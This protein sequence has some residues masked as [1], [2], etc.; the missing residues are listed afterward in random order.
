MSPPRLLSFATAL[1]AAVGLMW[2]ALYDP[3]ALPL[4]LL[5]VVHALA[6]L[7]GPRLTWAIARRLG[8]TSRAMTGPGDLLQRQR[9]WADLRLGGDVDVVVM[10]HAHAPV[11]ER[12]D[13]GTF[14][15]LGSFSD[16]GT[17]AVIDSEGV[18]LV[19]ARTAGSSRRRRRR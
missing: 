15:N 13:R 7:V 18:T 16:H 1:G 5:L 6:G 10:G 12:R 8:R 14:V 9:A 11:C 4:G 2:W 3:R 19:T 17:Y